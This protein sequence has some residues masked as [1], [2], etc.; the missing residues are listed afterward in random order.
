MGVNVAVSME[1]SGGRDNVRLQSKGGGDL[2]GISCLK[3]LQGIARGDTGSEDSVAHKDK[4]EGRTSVVKAMVG[5]SKATEEFMAKVTEKINEAVANGLDFDILKREITA[6]GRGGPLAEGPR[7]QEKLKELIEDLAVIGLLELHK[8]MA[9]G[10][11][12]EAAA[13]WSNELEAEAAN[14]IVEK[15]HYGGL[16]DAI[17]ALQRNTML[18][19]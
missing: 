18:P 9:D 16:E 1:Y 6:W 14:I 3:D 19:F 17:P 7:Y 10:K 4:R 8:D 11:L 15:N 12:P 5:N 13:E 2:G